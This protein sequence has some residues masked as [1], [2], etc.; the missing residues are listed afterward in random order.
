MEELVGKRVEHFIF[1]YDG[2]ER[3]CQG[4]VVSIKP[5]TETELTIRYDTEKNC[6][7]FITLSL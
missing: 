6:S 3:W 4:T 2:K 7:H 5:E 1:D